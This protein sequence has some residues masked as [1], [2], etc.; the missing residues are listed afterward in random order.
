MCGIAGFSGHFSQR[1]LIEM[2]ARIA[3]RG[4]DG[5]GDF[6]LPE[7]GIGL[8][9][10]RLSIIELSEAGHQPMVDRSG[11]V[12]ITFN[13]EI[14]NFLELRE[15]LLAAGHLFKGRS[16]TEVLLNMYLHHGEAMLPKL[17]G[18]FA[19]A[20]WDGRSQNLFVARDDF[21]VKPF[22]YA[23]TPRGLVFASELKALLCVPDV[24]KTIDP[25]AILLHLT[26]LWCPAPQTILSQVKKLEPGCAMRVRAGKIERAWQYATSPYD[27]P[28]LSLSAEE[29]AHQVEDAV[30]RAVTRQ[31]VADVPVGAFLS[32]GLDSS[33]I[34]AFARQIQPDLQCFTIGFQPGSRG[35]DGFADDWPYAHKV[36]QHLG[37]T[38]HTV[39]VGPEMTDRLE[40]MIYHL[41]EPLADPASF[42]TLFISQLAREHGIKVLLS[43]TGG[44]D[45]FSGYRRHYAL[46][47]E[48]YWGWMP[49]RVRQCLSGATGWL[50]TESPWL[51]RIRKAFEYAELTGDERLTSYFYWA[52]P[53]RLAGLLSEKNRAQESHRS[54]AEPFLSA[55]H[56]L[57]QGLPALHRLLFLE[58][59]FFLA[60]H[61][62]NYTDKM[63]MA[64]GV[65]VRVP[66]LDPDLVMLAAR[67]PVDFKQRGREGKWIFKKAMEKY[68]P[69]EVIYRPKS[70]FG[71]PL[72]SWLHHELKSLVADVLSHD[73][74][75]RRQIFDAG[76]VAHLIRQDAAG[77]IDATY[78]IFSMMCI[79]MWCRQFLDPV[80]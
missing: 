59:K 77:K 20:I 51:R 48:R 13:G 6:F 19:F 1:E 15:E 74:I 43:G 7:R 63:S 50:P 65:E 78:S 18:I 11:Q 12:V 17:N 21:G 35:A 58:R 47:Q 38:L 61:N 2:G 56:T 44:D 64:A 46:Q 24:D 26:Y 32:G 68:L 57:P 80:L 54:V 10:R 28:L 76:A 3:H 72:R 14:Y 9:H 55:L 73:A 4:P 37:V 69:K 52:P 60:D 75:A 31:M 71:V 45:I 29:A 41:D 36:A 66:L 30:R 5:A 70:G 33:A 27:Q 22:Y 49:Q 25:Y 23:Q 62:L 67:L 39:N 79:E 8:T 16:D 42:N 40:Q 53:Y 34:V